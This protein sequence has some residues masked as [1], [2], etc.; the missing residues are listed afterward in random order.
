MRGQNSLN[1][2]RVSVRRCFLMISTASFFSL[3][4]NLIGLE[5][6]YKTILLV[7]SN[8]LILQLKHPFII[9]DRIAS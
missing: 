3:R 5:L 4:V 1:L 2:P 7:N 9:L 6:F 8:I